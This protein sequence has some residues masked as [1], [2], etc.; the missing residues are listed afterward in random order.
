VKPCTGRV[1]ELMGMVIIKLGIV[2][3][4]VQQFVAKNV[5]KDHYLRE[6]LKR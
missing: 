3:S 1:G 2:G 5:A 4:S 6:S